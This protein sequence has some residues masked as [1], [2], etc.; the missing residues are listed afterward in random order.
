MAL[1]YT[2][3]P[4]CAFLKNTR[5]DRSAL[6]VTSGARFIDLPGFT[7][8]NKAAQRRSESRWGTE[9]DPVNDDCSTALRGCA[10][11]IMVENHKSK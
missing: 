10:A 6:A 8:G 2:D 5:P 9:Y 7:V 1:P 11:I 4:T 3:I